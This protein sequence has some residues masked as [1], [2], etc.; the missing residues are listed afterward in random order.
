[1]VLRQDP[2]VIGL[3]QDSI[4]LGHAPHVVTHVAKAALAVRRAHLSAHVVLGLACPRRTG[5]HNA[6][7]PLVLGN[8]GPIPPPCLGPAWT[9]PPWV[10]PRT[11]TPSLFGEVKDPTPMGPG[12]DPTP[13]VR[14]TPQPTW[15]RPRPKDHPTWVRTRPEPNNLVGCGCVQVHLHVGPRCIHA[16]PHVGSGCDR[17]QLHVGHGRVHTQPDVRSGHDQVLW[18]TQ[19]NWSSTGPNGNVS[20]VGPKS[21]GSYLRTQFA[22]VLV[23]TQIICVINIILVFLI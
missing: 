5:R 6:H 14:T 2:M 4:C 20:C 9:Q 10:R 1:M 17:V 3:R 16:Q 8:D 7:H 11:Q 19:C 23:R 18:W 12:I 21:N 15:V 13:W 22:W